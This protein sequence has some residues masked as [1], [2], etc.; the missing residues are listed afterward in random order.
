MK[1]TNK[2]S[3]VH[4]RAIE[5]VFWYLKRTTNFGLYCSNYHMVLEGYFDASWIIS[6]NDNKSTSGWIFTLKGGSVS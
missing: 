1:Y 4:W 6:S 5:R 2:P 3:M